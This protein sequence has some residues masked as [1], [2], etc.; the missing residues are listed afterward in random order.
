VSCL[1]EQAKILFAEAEE[2]NLGNEVWNERFARWRRCSL[3]EQKYHGVVACALGWA[4]WKTYVGRPEA[5]QARGYAMTLLGLGLSAAGRNED[6][7]SVCEAELAMKRSL[8]ASEDAILVVQTNLAC[9][10]STIG[11][12]EE[13]SQM[14]RDIYHGR[15]KLNGEEHE[16]T[17]RA[18]SNYAM[19]LSS[20]QRYAEAKSLQRKIIPVARRVL[21]ESNELTLKMRL[22]YAEA[23]INAGGVA[24]DDLREA[25]T[26][27]EQTTRTARQV[28]GI[29]HPMTSS[30]V[31]ALRDAR[32]RLSAREGAVAS[33]REAMAAMKAGDA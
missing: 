23:L 27:L 11:R 29:A 33:I 24:L 28:L 2:N 20:L 32:A 14:E 1:A 8:G 12:D 19:G 13:A 16:K 3:C 4:C 15:L 30:S 10:Y 17:L 31:K 18:A 9:T 5:D 21:G 7:L 25:V 6:A 26:T 22:N